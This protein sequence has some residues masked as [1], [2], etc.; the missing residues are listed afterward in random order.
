MKKV[1]VLLTAGLLLVGCSSAPATPNSTGQPTEGTK[2]KFTVAMECNYAP[3][4]WTQTTANDTAVQISATDYCDGYD[5]A[6]AR[7]IADSLGQEL[8]IKS[9]AWEGLITGLN[10][11]EVDAIIAGMTATPER[12]EAIDFTKPYYES[13]MVMIVRGDDE[14]ANA[15]SIQD[16]TGKKVLGQINTLY[17]DVIDQIEGVN[18]MT[19]QATYPRMVLSLQQGEVDGLT[20]EL[21]VAQ[22]VVAANPDLKIVTFEEGKGFDADTTVSI[23]IKKG[24]TELLNKVQAALDSITEEERVEIM[25]AATD[26]QPATAE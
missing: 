4:N 7:K 15:T 9:I 5:V 14:L 19:P 13:Q 26:R 2:E 18:H 11:D 23:A 21:P 25:K 8:E 16:F 24:N 12:A 3:F 20:A 6:I 17:D 22:G 10:N 1:L